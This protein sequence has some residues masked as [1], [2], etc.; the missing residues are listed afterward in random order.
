MKFFHLF[1]IAGLFVFSACQGQDRSKT[2]A[3]TD[4]AKKIEVIDFYGT[5]RCV[6]CKAIEA[7]TKYTI[8][9]YFK[10]AVKKGQLEFKTV[11]VDEKENYD[12][13]ENFEATGTALFINVVKDGKEQHIDLTNFAFEKGRDQQ[14]FSAELKQKL[15]EQLNML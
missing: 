11:N 1:F 14:A 2:V 8:D 4:T 10:D 12:M 7:N 6:T 5:H 15:E 3:T 13:A 9:N